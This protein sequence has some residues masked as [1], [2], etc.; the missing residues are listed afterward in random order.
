M[1]Y[2]HVSESL[3]ERLDNL[4]SRQMGR[5]PDSWGRR[6]SDYHRVGDYYPHTI[7]ERILH[8]NIG[9]SFDEAF[10]YFCRICPKYQQRIFLDLFEPS[11]KGRHTEWS[12]NVEGNIVYNPYQWRSRKRLPTIKS[13][14]F[15]TELRHKITGHSQDKF[16]RI[17]EKIE[18]VHEYG[19]IGHRQTRTY[20][21]NGKL[22]HY[23]YGADRFHMR[24][25]ECRYTAI[26]D[27][28]ETVIISGWIRY[29]ESKND[30]EF[31]RYKSEQQ[32]HKRRSQKAHKRLMKE[33]EYNFLSQ[34]EIQMKKDKALDRIKIVSHGFDLITSFRTDKQTNPD[35]I[36]EKGL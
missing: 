21:V 20:T 5:D 17:Y 13:S 25:I 7:A 8:H 29:F 10:G 23:E 15:N 1:K 27:D 22:L 16:E 28:F 3:I 9:K 4:P 18:Q 26:D 32:K 14:N 6:R 30:P 35:L 12:T 36:Q 34:S 11:Y 33:M 19:A 31:I 24:P 2:K